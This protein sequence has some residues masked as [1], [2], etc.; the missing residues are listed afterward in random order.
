M[1]KVSINWQ[2]IDSADSLRL[3]SQ[4]IA[5]NKDTVSV[6]G[7]ESKPRVPVPSSVTTVN[8]SGN[9]MYFDFLH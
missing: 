4:V 6:F 2:C 9:G 5:V 8:L 3:S 7:G 1:A